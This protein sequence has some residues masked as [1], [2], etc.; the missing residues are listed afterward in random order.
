FPAPMVRELSAS[1]P[2]AVVKLGSQPSGAGLT[3][4]AADKNA[5]QANTAR[6]LSNI[7]LLLVIVNSFRCS[8]VVNSPSRNSLLVHNHFGC[9]LTHLELR[10]YFLNLCSL[11][12]HLGRE[13]L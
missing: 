6:L 4:R 13:P 10:V 2:S 11:F 9:R 5:K 8:K 1:H 12:F 7:V 3:A